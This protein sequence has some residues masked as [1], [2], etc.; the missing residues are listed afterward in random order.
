MKLLLENLPPSLSGQRTAIEQCLRAMDRIMPL[1]AVYLFGSHVR[2]KARPDSDV[3]LCVIADE[4]E[5]QVPASRRLSGA[6]LE[7]WP[8]PAFTL[9]P[10]TPKRMAEKRCIRDPFFDTVLTEGVLLATEDR[11]K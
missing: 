6:V 4:A 10:I 8:R 7:V 2:G 5:R 9:V 1:R 11:L 3:D